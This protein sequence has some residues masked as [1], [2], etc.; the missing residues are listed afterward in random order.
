MV[1]TTRLSTANG[2]KNF[3]ET[4]HLDRCDLDILLRD[5]WRHRTLVRDYCSVTYSLENQSLVIDGEI[6]TK[7][8]ELLG[9]HSNIS[10]CALLLLAF[11]RLLDA[12]GHGSQTVISFVDTIGKKN[13]QNGRLL[14]SV[15]DHSLQ[16]NST[17]IDAIRAIHDELCQHNSYVRP[18]DLMQ[19]GLFD[20]VIVQ[21]DSDHILTDIPPSPLTGIFR[22]IESQGCLEWT[23]IY[24]GELFED[25]VIS[26]VIDVLY[27]ILS[28]LVL[29][30]IKLIADLDL[31]SK[32]Q[33]QRIDYWNAT[34]GDF[35]RT[36][37][38]EN[39]FEDALQRTPDHR[40]IICGDTQ[41]SYNE[42]NNQCNWISHW[43]HTSTVDFSSGEL[44]ALYL[45]KSE[46]TV[47]TILGIWKAGAA[48]V[49]I[50]PSYPIERVLFILSD[51]QVTR[52]ITNRHY[53]EQ[54]QKILDSQQT[55]TQIIEVEAVLATNPGNLNQSIYENLH[56]DNLNILD[57]EQVAY[58]TYTS[59]TTGIPKGVPK[60]H[61]S[62]VNSIT[63]LSE[64]YNMLE[65]GTER[66]A[67]FAAYVFEPFFRQ[68]LIALIN[69]QSLVVVPDEIKLH[70]HHF[71]IF[72]AR[73]GITYLNGT[74]SVLQHFDLNACKSLKRILLVGEELTAVGL[75]RLREK[76]NGRIINEYAFTEAAF[77]T[78]IKEFA[79][80]VEDRTDR[81]IGKPLRNVKCYVLSQDLKEVP[82]GAIGELY[83]G[84]S[85][86][87]CGYLNRESLTAERFLPN[88][89]QVEKEKSR[90]QNSRIYKTGDLVRRLPNGELEFMG[91]SDFQLK[92][93]GVR[94]EPGEIEARATEYP[95]VKQCVVV[96]YKNPDD[97]D[98]WHLVGY[99]VADELSQVTEIKLLGFLEEQLIR[100]MVPARMIRLSSMPV[101]VNG[102]VDRRALPDI[103]T[104]EQ[105]KMDATHVDSQHDATSH[106]LEAS[107]REIWSELLKIPLVSIQTDDDFF[108]LGGH[109]ITCIQLLTRIWEEL[110]LVVTVEDVFTL[111]TLSSLA[112]FLSQLKEVS[113]VEPSP[114]R[115]SLPAIDQ[116]IKLQANG[117]QQGLMYHAM[118]NEGDDAY[119]MQT[120]YRYNCTIDPNQMNQAWRCAQVKY[121]SLR[122]RFEWGVEALQIIDTDAQ[123][124]LDWHFLDLSSIKDEKSR[125][126]QVEDLRKQDRTKPYSMDTG[127]LFRVY[128]IKL[129]NDLYKLLFSC[130][131]IILDGW[132]LPLLHD[133]VHRIYLN[134]LYGDTDHTI[135]SQIDTSYIAAQRYWEVHR[136]DHVDYWTNQLEKIGERIDLSGL[137]NEQN[138][139]KVSLTSYDYV[140]QHKTEQLGIGFDQTS[141]LKVAC[142]AHGLTLHSVLQFVWHKTLHAFGA[143]ETTVVGTIVSG[144]NL[145]IDGIQNSIGLFINTLPIIV[146][147]REQEAKQLAVAISEIQASTNAMN[148]RSVVDLAHLQSSGIKHQLF[149]SLLVLENYPRLLSDAE[150][151]QH[152]EQLRFERVYD[153]DKVNYPLAVVAREKNGELV[154][155]LWYAGELFDDSAISSLLE[156]V[157]TLFSQV[158]ENMSQSVRDLRFVSTNMIDQFEDWN[159]TRVTFPDSKTLHS[160]FEEIV[161]Q[162][163]HEIAVVFGEKQLTYCELNEQ[164]NQL[165]HLLL[166]TVELQAN[167]LIAL[168]LD[169]SERMIVAILAVWKAGAGYVPIDPSY[170]DERIAFML[171]DTQ[172][173]ILITNELYGIHLHH[174]SKGKQ[175]PILELEKQ[176]LNNQ[177]SHNPITRTSSRDLAYTIYTSGTTGKPKGVQVEHLG[178][179][180]LHISLAKI[181]SLGRHQSQEVLLSFS[182]YVFDHFVEQM[183]DALLNGQTLVILDDE[184]R[185]DKQRLYRYMSENSITYLSG[186][187]SVLSLYDFS[188][189]KSLKRIDAIGEDFTEPVFQKIR[190]TFQGTIINGYGPTEIS[191]TSHKRLYEI[192]E[193]RTN[194]SIGFPINNTA[195]YVLNNIMKRVPVGGVGELFIG[196]VGVTRGYL[197]RPDITAERFIENPFQTEIEQQFSSNNRLYK[198]GDL[199]RWLPNGELE[200]LGRND[201]QVKIRGQRIELGEIEAVLS[202]YPGISR[203]FVIARTYSS[204][205]DSTTPQKYLVGFYLSN[206]EFE[207]QTL[208]RWMRTKL[209][210]ALV[211]TRLIQ[212]DEIPVTASGKLDIR[213]LP[214]TNFVPSINEDYEA[215]SSEL[216]SA[217]CGIWSKV[218]S[219]EPEYI[220]V[221]DD[222]FALG[223]DSLRAIT[224]SQM[225]T[226]SFGYRFG[227]A[228]AF[229]YA[230]IEAQAD[231][232][233]NCDKVQKVEE[234][235]YSTE[236]GALHEGNPPVSL[237]QERLLFID[238]LVGGSAAYNIPFVIEIQANSKQTKKRITQALVALIRRHAALRTFL[239]EEHDGIRLQHILDE[240]EIK[241]RFIV[242]H[243]T[244]SD[245]KNLDASLVKETAQRFFLESELPIRA[246]IFELSGIDKL[247]VSIVV[248][249]SCFDGWSWTVFRRELAAL[250]NG[251]SEVALE[252]PQASYADF[253]LWQRNRLTGK[254]LSNLTD[255]WKKEL[256]DFHPINL[257]LDRPR[258]PQFDYQ[259]QEV[260]FEIDKALVNQLKELAKLARVSFYS[261]LLSA[262]GLMLSTYTDQQD[263]VI[264]TPSANRG[265]PEFDNV[266]GFFANLLVLRVQVNSKTI[267]LDYLRSVGKA[268]VRAQAH[269][270]LPFEKLVKVLQVEKDLSR[271]PI[272]QVVFSLITEETVECVNGVPMKSY[273][274]DD[275][276]R[277]TVKFD[278]SV[279]MTEV[280]N[281]LVGNFTYAESLFDLASVNQWISSFQKILAEFA[282][283]LPFAETAEIFDIDYMD[284]ITREQLLSD[285]DHTTSYQNHCKTLHSLFEEIVEQW[286]HEI[287]VVF[288]E[289]QLT[290]CELNEQANQLAHLLLDTVEL[291]ANDLIALML[292]KSERMIVAILAVW[293]AGAGYVPIDPSYPDERIAFMLEDTQSKILITNELYGIHLHHLSKGKQLP[294]LELEKQILNNQPS[295]NPITRTSSRDLAYTI[296]TSGTTGKPKGVLITHQN[297]I[298]LYYDIT[299]RYFSE[300]PEIRESILFLSNY[301]FDFSIEQLLLSIFSGNKLVI[302]PLLLAF[303]TEFYDYA[304]NQ[305]ITYLS[306]TPTQLQQFDLSKFKYLGLVLVAGEAFQ[307]HH[308]DKIRREYTGPLLNAYGTTE[309][310]VY[311]TVMRFEPSDTYHNTL[312]DPLSNTQLYVLNSELE[313]LPP[314]A[315]GELII[316][317]AC[318]SN[319]YLHRSELT[320]QRFLPNPFKTKKDQEEEGS[321]CSLIYKTGDV[322]RRRPDGQL[323]FLGRNDSQ[324]KING[325]RIEL[326]E[327]EAAIASYPGIRQ[328]TVLPREDKGTPDYERLVGY[329]VLEETCVVDR[330]D[331]FNFLRM[332]LTPGMLPRMLVEIE[333]RLP[334]TINGKLDVNALPAVEFN[335]E[336]DTYTAPRNR[337]E[338][339][340]CRIWSK[341]L[342][343]NIIGI[344]D[345]F[346]RCGGDSIMALQLAS[347]IQQKLKQRV[348]VKQIFDFPTVRKFVE[349]ALS[350]TASV[351]KP[352]TQ[353]QLTGSCPMLPVQK[354][355]FTKPLVNQVHWNQYFAICTTL[356]D[357][358][359]LEHALCKLVRH[360]D[361]FRLRFHLLTNKYVE[362]TYSDD[363]P[364][365]Q[366]RTLDIRTLSPTELQS[367]LREFQG[368]FDFQTG[369]LYCAAYLHGFKDNTARIWIAMHHLIV[370]TV[371]WHILTQDLKLLY[372]GGE[373]GQKVSSYKLWAQ[374][375]KGYIPAPGEVEF[376]TDIA[377]SV[378][379]SNKKLLSLRKSQHNNSRHSEYFEL[380]KQNTQ[381]LLVKSQ[382]AYN[383]KI[384]ELLLAAV[385]Y[386]LRELTQKSLNYVTIEKHGR[387]AFDSVQDVQDTVGW[388]T[389]MYPIAVEINDDIAQSIAYAKANYRQ[390]PNNGIGYGLILGTYGSEQAPL[391]SVSFNYLGQFLTPHTVNQQ[392]LQLNSTHD[393]HLDT[394]LC[395]MS[396]SLEDKNSNDCCIDITMRCVG[397]H[398]IT[399]VNSLLGE[400]TTQLFTNNLKTSLEEIIKHTSTIESTSNRQVTRVTTLSSTVH[401]DFE[402]YI[403]LNEKTTKP[404]L[405]ILPPGEGGA[406]SYLNNIAK[407][408]TDFRLVLFNNIHLHQPMDS[409]EALAQYYISHI[410]RLEPS[411]PYSFL[412]WSFGGVLSLEISLQLS[413]AG[414]TIDNLIFVDSLFDVRKATTAIGLSGVDNIIDPINYRYLPET[415][416]LRHLH[417]HTNNILL[418]KAT[419]PSEKFQGESQRKLFEYYAQSS[420]NNLDTVLPTASI[421]VELLPNDTHFSW[422]KNATTVTSMTSKIRTLMQKNNLA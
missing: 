238:N 421:S 123:I 299:L 128:L 335:A 127:P 113:S 202:S 271:H 339:R 408:L 87:A 231:H 223:G 402:P 6:Y 213:S 160:L 401:S 411:G 331:I 207:E 22:D 216:E 263:I 222:F 277:T 290:Y 74:R 406:E 313:L 266:I 322:V 173:K 378:L 83:I 328:C 283:L 165:A 115:N 293:K 224:L 345:D 252:R 343:D 296:Y 364:Q 393:W 90:E 218:L 286:P 214:N 28:Q 82:I 409:F 105:A 48:F 255:F 398:M 361:A 358:N 153:I 278:L 372:E 383:T 354:W 363:I 357:P 169:K 412:G 67:L 174:L 141:T 400:N 88:P 365:I 162:W 86:V 110:R 170:P 156:T 122:L 422:V 186:T 273:Y 346:F 394:D 150:I 203:S 114:V 270:E 415:D 199:V 58:V 272:V 249:H 212:I 374:S 76:F 329:Y 323:E 42:L 257:P 187:P 353:E 139:Y 208:K 4:A 103:P 108:R 211:P 17:G 107:L 36:K 69:S 396:C 120:V 93:N 326:G 234:Q 177:P 379:T 235:C 189:V 399:E 193:S 391:P 228:A 111:K 389:T 147:H 185:T 360:H 181:F 124:P 264:G 314:G 307:A 201:F 419:Q 134:L 104:C 291:Q 119:V 194:K 300:T 318:I 32:E 12:Y 279:T 351:T 179:V 392:G 164:A 13:L 172:S 348:S 31:I 247:Y 315:I 312:G 63:D 267:L 117:L 404:T 376:W 8:K 294:I 154:I 149:D 133:E 77:V 44:I 33:K 191:I 148:G 14:P 92:L 320:K 368:S 308:F 10:L 338:S 332:R 288:G 403:I 274:P 109:S 200:Y 49:P 68:M 334:I 417:T 197:N 121:P 98:D 221:R 319:G 287:A 246:T 3:I 380:D 54:L 248:H 184:M 275:E 244:V 78:A 2:W 373:L 371:S 370:D 41:L 309:T 163:P 155:D 302:P 23:F 16:S 118:K 281:G 333:G 188:S 395:G 226:D 342:S 143:G 158:I 336:Q 55:S 324:V 161:E 151:K 176:I 341:L 261:L 136:K 196:G 367:K 62:V 385:G 349:N 168:M 239:R 180:N 225:L 262:Y 337:I 303:D 61:Y 37:R 198:T 352:V 233:Q 167:D 209:S 327:V 254:Q 47:I 344:D 260:L 280:A 381:K 112:T 18:M 50:D 45:D 135:S 297:V 317:G 205:V 71:P 20:A 414:E 325:L 407:H 390:V 66:V 250:L 19:Q 5:E 46:L 95:G 40:A 282:R 43:L 97:V 321:H 306:G 384:N 70:S 301:V 102:K 30:P 57:S 362:Q 94:V 125:A 215:P 251:V 39:L 292:D 152:T 91:R 142:A 51:T 144:R 304:N 25:K 330:N 7:L 73:S 259:G 311:N 241:T 26:G 81:S 100:V 305:R 350:S 295:H 101:N 289:K 24:A 298:S 195:C 145:P 217:L 227:V 230:T 192:N 340:L 243:A 21:A 276:G 89:F 29:H 9:N 137:L 132:S 418:F 232:I 285:V 359:K 237:A 34:D 416:A 1:A 11:H 220:G 140:Q 183:T 369:P 178:V 240:E 242:A 84:G 99:F 210:E 171:E 356:L 253:A 316:S 258:P 116:A 190:N 377:E 65:A 355:F 284:E 96:A 410:R 229:K 56:C 53:T 387:D 268:V 59:G 72:I 60:Q 27:E 175:L 38:L 106:N 375:L 204:T 397:D 405:F 159:N 126:N 382:R 35:P 166:D 157:Q 182:N 85:G 219:I 52:L 420:I 15:I 413:Q 130:H 138:R 131:H 386:A 80:G 79:V 206:N 146:N 256:I 236:F 269:Q 245:S 310:T 347:Q 265:R 366:L 129:K 75:Q 64:R 388:F